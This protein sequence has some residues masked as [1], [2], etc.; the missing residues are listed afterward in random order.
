[1]DD[2][3]IGKGSARS[4]TGLHL[5]EALQRC[6]PY[7]DKFGGHEMAAGLTIRE[8]RIAGFAGAF[9]RAARDLLSDEDLQHRLRLD[10]ELSLSD[11]NLDLLHWHEMLQP[12]GNANTQPL[13]LARTVQPAAPPKVLN[14]K[15]LI[16]RLRQGNS[17]R[18]AVFFSGA[19][20]PLPPPP[21]DIAFRIR[22]D[23][24]EGER[25]V[26]IQIEA[27]RPSSSIA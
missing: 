13:F 4:I 23:D 27:L 14:D 17:H 1:M 10:H 21:W 22:P 18:R 20:E 7:L 11:L 26:G 3:G 8:D 25:L 6:A 16:L 12:F 2:N 15:H 5:V 24:Y 19:V 9:R